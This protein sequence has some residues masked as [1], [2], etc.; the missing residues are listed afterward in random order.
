MCCHLVHCVQVN[1]W[2]PGER[3]L[4]RWQ[5]LLRQVADQYTAP[6]PIKLVLANLPHGPGRCSVAVHCGM[7][8]ACR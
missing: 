4:S 7:Y 6:Q 1:E 5:A 2:T 3:R 8:C